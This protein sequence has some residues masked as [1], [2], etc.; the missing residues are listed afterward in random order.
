MALLEINPDPAARLDRDCQHLLR[1]PLSDQPPDGELIHE[2]LKER[3]P[4]PI[5]DLVVLAD[6]AGLKEMYASPPMTQAARDAA[7]MAEMLAARPMPAAPPQARVAATVCSS[8]QFC[9]PGLPGVAL[10]GRVVQENP[11]NGFRGSNVAPSVRP[12]ASA[13][14]PE[15]AA[16]ARTPEIGA[17]RSKRSGEGR[18]DFP[19]TTAAPVPD[20]AERCHSG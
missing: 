4:S 14:I 1:V 5:G 20:R 9:G 2:A 8:R 7:N 16:P 10:F 11:A 19:S 12:R 6:Q 3:A 18:D 13:F 15:T 17:A